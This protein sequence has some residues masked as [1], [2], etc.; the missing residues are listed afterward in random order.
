[1][2][3]IEKI[4][5]AILTKINQAVGL[6]AV[7]LADFAYPPNPELGDLTL[8]CFALAKRLG[9]APAE[10]ADTL[11]TKLKS[12]EIVQSITSSGP[13]LNFTVADRW[14]AQESVKAVVN[15]QNKYGDN[16]SG[17]N[18]GVMIEY[19]NANTHKE[20]HVGHLRNICFGDAIN[21]LAAANGFNSVP[22]SYINDF[23]IHVAKTLWCYSEF[24]KNEP[25][26]E[27]KGYFLGKVY[28][29]SAQELE[30]NEYGKRMVS[31]IMKKIESRSG[32]EYRLWQETR[33]WSIEQFARI[34]QELDVN[35]VKT[36]YE[37]ELIERGKIIIDGLIAK[38]VL[39]KSEGAII[40]DLTTEKLGVL[41][42]YRSDGTALY[43]VADLPLAIQKFQDFDL[44]KSIYVT[45]VRQ[46]LYFQQLFK[47]IALLG[48]DQELVHLGYEFVK[49]P[50]GMMSSRSGNV[51]T[52]EELKEQLLQKFTEETK[53][54][55]ADWTAKKINQVAWEL[56][57]AAMKFEMLKVGASNVITFDINQAMEFNG[58]TAAY[59]QYTYARLNSIFKKAGDAPSDLKTTQFPASLEKLERQLI[60]KANKYPEAV[61][62]AWSSYD[63]S[64]IAKYLFELSQS[65][66]DYYHNI[67]ILKSDDTQ[68]LFRIAVLK[69][70]NQVL[71]NGLDLLGINTIEEM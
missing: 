22:V 17:G 41:M 3:P 53:E 46:A 64:I 8:P 25:Q 29:R 54:R 2:Y 1:M 31:L 32:D 30:E 26:P 33:Q 50:S 20:F 71:A 48:H 9:Q 69:S 65:A 12:D 36:Y 28:A 68:K 15:L 10:I 4:K 56:T 66:N 49:L 42:F 27:N 11:V 5:L 44:Q 59:I 24:Y 34:Y 61:S 58:Y 35:F 70:V 13:Y 14:L 62:Q 51:I 55:H 18:K 21:R 7:D 45:D 37:S 19:S 57:M 6:E 38:N 63:P 40:A 67:P 47:I 52:Y 60:M 39:V 16:Q 23:G 43:P